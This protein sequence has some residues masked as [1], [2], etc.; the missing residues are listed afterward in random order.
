LRNGEDNKLSVTLCREI[1]DALGNIRQQLGHGTEGALIVRG[2]NAKFFTNVG[3]NNAR[4][5]RRCGRK[6]Y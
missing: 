4:R 3:P 5:Q 1:I 6:Q 2:S